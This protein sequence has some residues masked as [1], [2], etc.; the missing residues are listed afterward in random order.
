PRREGVGPPGVGGERRGG[1]RA[2]EGD[3]GGAVLLRE[4]EADGLPVPLAQRREERAVR[5]DAAVVVLDDLLE[6]E[7]PAVVHVGRREGDVAEGADLETSEP[8]AAVGR[9]GVEAVR[10]RAVGDHEVAAVALAAAGRAE[11]E[12][13]PPVLLVG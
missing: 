1:E 5:L 4:V 6:A 2:E 12:L 3:E 13:E 8:D 9:A 11:E 7:E 10:E